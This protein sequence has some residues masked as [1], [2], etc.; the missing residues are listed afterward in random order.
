MG[1]KN[2]ISVE[3]AVAC[4][5]GTVVAFCLRNTTLQEVCCDPLDELSVVR[6]FDGGKTWTGR[7]SFLITKD[8]SMM[9]FTKMVVFM[10]CSF[11]MMV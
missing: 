3:K 2:T 7:Y 6:S 8:V 9:L 1:G 11:A 10:C 5:D 4:D